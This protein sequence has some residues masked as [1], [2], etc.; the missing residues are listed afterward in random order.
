MALGGRIID[1]RFQLADQ[2]PVQ[3]GLAMF[4]QPVLQVDGLF[5]GV[6]P[7][8]AV[9]ENAA[10]QDGQVDQ[11]FAGGLRGQ[12]V[13]YQ[14]PVAVVEGAAACG[15]DTTHGGDDGKIRHF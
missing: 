2:G 1:I 3:Q 15:A 6:F 5:A 9:I 8:G 13:V 12:L 14:A 7:V 10:G 11:C 4:R